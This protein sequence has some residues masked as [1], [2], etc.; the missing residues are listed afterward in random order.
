MN[1]IKKLFSEKQRNILSIFFTAGYPTLNDTAV[2]A[3]ALESSGA[4]MIEIGIPFSDPVADGPVIQA[5]NKVALGNGMSLR[6]LI[7]QVKDIRSTVS[8]P[9][10]L[11]GYLNPIMQYGIG[12][13]IDDAA[14]AGVDGLIIPDLPP[15][16]YRDQYQARVERAGLCVAFLISPATSEERVRMIDS[17][18]TGFIY[19]VSASSTTG[20]TSHFSGEH[21]VYF[22]KLQAMNLSNPVMI[23]FGIGSAATFTTA[24]TYAQGAIIGSAFL[25]SLD[26]QAIAD[27]VPAFIN[28]LRTKTV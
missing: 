25:K 3:A 19:A 6:L 14:G 22:K 20:S 1:R 18:S 12:Q 5:T 4:D 13:F 24:C 7:E 9:I 16:E 2:L 26:N 15:A 23:G 11:M 10:L 17:L 21:E 28:T 27:A 8:I